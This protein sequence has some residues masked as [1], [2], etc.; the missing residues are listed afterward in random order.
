MN[1]PIEV[2]EATRDRRCALFVGR[3]A[4]LEAVVDSGGEYPDQKRLARMLKGRTSI[5]EASAAFE[6]R[7]GRAALI[8][9]LTEHHGAEGTEP[10]SFHMDAVKRFP[11]IFTTCWDDLLERAADAQGIAYEVRYGGDPIPLAGDTLLIYKI[12][13]G[14]EAPDRM[15][16]TAGDAGKLVDIRKDVRL[17]V[18]KNVCFF[19]G[20]RPDEEDF[21]L[22]FDE[23]S[24]AYGGELPR[25]HLAVAQG[26]ISDYHWQKWVWR[27]LLL[28]IADPSE[29]AQALAEQVDA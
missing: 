2:V 27:G 28:F 20:Y 15:V 5:R 17:V 19:V 24:E 11:R 13:G 4:T 29:A 16:L 14:F 25:C 22:I 18:R 21:D 23:I 6:E 7:L 9:V 26:K 10:G 8:A 3:R 1:V 12:W